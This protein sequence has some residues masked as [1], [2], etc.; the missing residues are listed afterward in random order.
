MRSATVWLAAD[1]ST[2]GSN[3]RALSSSMD[4]DHRPSPTSPIARR[5]TAWKLCECSFDR[6]RP[7]SNS[8]GAH[9]RNFTSRS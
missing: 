4:H 5:L 9:G 7:L 3:I 1:F 8:L 6:L 2:P